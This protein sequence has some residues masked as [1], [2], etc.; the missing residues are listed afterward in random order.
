MKVDPQIPPE[1]QGAAFLVARTTGPPGVSPVE[2]STED[3][4]IESS[5]IP[6][7]YKSAGYE[8]TQEW[9]LPTF[10]GEDDARLLLGL[11]QIYY[12]D[13]R[14]IQVSQNALADAL[15]RVLPGPFETFKFRTQTH[16]TLGGEYHLFRGDGAAEQAQDTHERSM[17][18]ALLELGRFVDKWAATGKPV[19]PV[20]QGLRD[21]LLQH[22][23]DH[24]NEHT[25][26][27]VEVDTS[28]FPTTRRG[29]KQKHK[30]IE[31]DVRRARRNLKG[32][33]RDINRLHLSMLDQLP[34]TFGV[35]EME[36]A[37][38]EVQWKRGRWG[39]GTTPTREAR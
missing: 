37:E 10:A 7:G 14:V 17:L 5:L 39:V 1:G 12:P 25:D 3:Y 36:I 32:A 2:G 13:A 6:L 27:K 26:E 34:D 38:N 4:K 16:R 19:D 23:R 20:S 15:E 31:T 29:L 28:D 21:A 8:Q 18:T 33:Q 11:Y 24:S 9:T 35:T 30:E 22:K